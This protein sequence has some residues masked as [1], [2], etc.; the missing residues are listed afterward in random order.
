MGTKNNPGNYDC[1]AKAAPDEPIFI[2][3]GKDPIAPFLVELWVASRTGRWDECVAII[4]RA[5]GD[6]A[7]GG[8]VSA[9]NYDKL[10][11]ALTCAESMRKWLS[12]RS[13]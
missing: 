6:A 1:Y 11:E 8:R 13:A 10:G 4:G 2:L 5:A 7:V 3:R 12:A 9:D